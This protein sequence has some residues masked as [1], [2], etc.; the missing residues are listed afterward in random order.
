M[1]GTPWSDGTVDASM[2]RM[3]T[4]TNYTQQFV[5]GPAGTHLYMPGGDPLL[6]ARGL[7]GAL[8]VKPKTDTR[9]HLYSDELLMQ[10]SDAWHEPETCLVQAGKGGNPK[11]PPI[12]KA[13]FDGMY[14]D[15]SNVYPY[16]Y[17]TV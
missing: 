3:Q 16:P 5:A 14:G 6:G 9:A 17:Y 4:D 1:R 2:G 13:T 12:D 10:I 15:G 11:C 8:I 7:K